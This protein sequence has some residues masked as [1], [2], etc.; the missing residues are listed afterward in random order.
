MTTL[1]LRKL[2]L[3]PAAFPET[4]EPLEEVGAREPADAGAAFAFALSRIA[5][6]DGRPVALVTTDLWLRERGRPF[7]RGLGGLRLLWVAVR[8]EAEALWALEEVLKSGAVAGALATVESV[9][10]VAG[11]RLD[12]A[13]HAGR[14]TGVIL[15]TSPAR[16]L[17][18]ARRRWRIGALGSG[19]AAFDP[20][21][22][23]PPRW[24]AELTRRRDGPPGSWD[25]E[26]EDETGRLRV[27]AGLADHGVAEDGGGVQTHA[28][29]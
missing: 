20:R 3:T 8:K 22:P 12:F 15:R 1:P 13:A 10:F 14:A 28:A 24:R 23:G 6:T 11:R 5:G 29:A 25:L 27:V 2:D 26:Q 7:A 16:E 9:P 17:S 18:A 19:E 21:A 4:S